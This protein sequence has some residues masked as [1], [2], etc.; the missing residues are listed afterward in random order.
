MINLPTPLVLCY[1]GHCASCH[2]VVRFLMRRSRRDRF[3]FVPLSALETHL[4]ENP[5]EGLQAITAE[6]TARSSLIVIKNGSVFIRASAV[7][8]VISELGIPWNLILIAR[9]L[10]LRLWNAIYTLYAQNRFRLF[11]AAAPEQL[12]DRLPTE[13]A[14]YLLPT[15]SP[16]TTLFSPSS[17]VFISAQW[18]ALMILN[19]VVPPEILTPYLPEGVTLDYWQEDCLVSV[20]A[21]SF[22][23]TSFSMMRLPFYSD[24]LEVNLRFYVKKT[25]IEDGKPVLRRG[26]VF[27]KELVPHVLIAK[28]A[29]LLYNENYETAQMSQHYRKDEAQESL[30]YHWQYGRDACSITADF[31]GDPIPFSPGS[32]EDF[33]TEHYYG[34]AKQKRRTQEYQVDHPQWRLWP[35]AR[36]TVSGDIAKPYPAA[37]SPYLQAPHST[38]F[39]EGSPVRVLYPSYLKFSG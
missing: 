39:A 3:R 18:R 27:V 5:V 10:P 12:C 29:N 28:T 37:F 4:S 25:V 32:L 20:V 13:Q 23:S 8:S 35:N 19:Y 14:Q 11:G 38:L 26:V 2:F 34:Y 24:F 21:F 6:L 22:L 16:K 36:L 9:I 15:L 30:E 1:D 17:R 7:F 31:S 33:I